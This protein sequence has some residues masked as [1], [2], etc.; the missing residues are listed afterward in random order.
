MVILAAAEMASASAVSMS[1]TA[2]AAFSISANLACILPA[3]PISVSS[4]DMG[5]PNCFSN[6]APNSVR[7]SSIPSSSVWRSAGLR[8]A[9]ARSSALKAVAKRISRSRFIN[10]IDIYLGRIWSRLEVS[11]IERLNIG[12]S[13]GS[14]EIAAEDALIYQDL[15]L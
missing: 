15:A 12:I 1:W 11:S 2:R 3:F 5:T 14:D 7:S 8:S 6:V 13:E 4:P 10:I 9:K